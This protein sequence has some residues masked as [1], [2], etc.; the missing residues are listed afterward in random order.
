MTTQFCRPPKA[1]MRLLAVRSL[2]VSACALTITTARPLAAQ[3]GRITGLVT[4][5][6]GRPLA[7]TQVVVVPAG[8]Y[9]AMASV[10]GHYTISDI[11]PGT[12]RLQ[13]RRIGYAPREQQVTVSA[14]QT[15]IADF[16]LTAVPARLDTVRVG[17]TTQERRSVSDATAGTTGDELRTEKTATVEEA[18]RG[19]IPGVQIA[20]SGEPG[21]PAQVIIRGQNFVATSSGQQSPLYVV[22]G[23]YLQQNPNLNP[24]D[25]ESLE[26]LKDASAAAQ[27]GAQAANGVI[28]IR[29]RHGRA[30]E[31]RVELH[32]YYGYQD[33]PKRVS[34]MNTAQWAALTTQAYTNAG[35]PVIAGAATPPP[36]STDWQ[37]AVFTRGGIQ[38]HNLAM[39]GGSETANYLLS[40]GYL[41][42]DGA[43]INTG[44]ERY[45]FRVNSEARRSWIT[46]GENLAL[47]TSSKKN[48][49]G[50]PLIDALRM[51][52]TIPVYDPT[53]SS[54]FGFGSA[55]NPTF[56]VNPVG[57]QRIEDNTT[58]SNQV[59]GTTYAEIG[60]PAQLRYRFN[61]GIN[62]ENFGGRDFVRMGQLRLNN[63]LVPARLSDAQ[64]NTLSLLFE[65]LLTFDNTF[66]D[67]AHHLN[68]V[69][70]LTEQR[71]TV[72]RLS[73]YREGYTNYSLTTIDAGLTSNL[74]NGGNRFESALRALL[75]RAN[76]VFKDRYI[77]TGSVRRDGSSRFGPKNKYG[78]FGAISGGWVLSQEDFY[79]TM[80]LLGR[81]GY[82]K[83]RAS[84]GVLGNQ[85]IGDY[86]FDAAINQNL[87][88][89]FGNGVAN[90]ST[91][92]SL[93]NPNI[94]WQSNRETNVGLDLGAWNDRLSFTADYYQS[95]SSDILV[96]AP[97]PPSLGATGSPVVNAGSVRNTG[98]EFGATHKYEE[99]DL[100]LRTGATLTTVRNKVL[101][102]GNN[103]QPIIVRGV[104]RTAV[105][106][107]IGEF[108]VFIT[109]GIIQNA[110]EAAAVQAS[111]PG[112]VPGDIRY[113]KLSGTPG[114]LSDADRGYAGSPNPD[115]VGGLFMN[116]TYRRFDFGIN[117]HGS[118]GNKIFNVARWWTDRMDDLSNYRAGL[119]PWTPTNTATKTPRAVFGPAG[120]SNARYNSDRWIEDGSYLR[121]QNVSL[122][123]TLPATLA[124]RG[125]LQSVEPRLYLNIQNLYTFTHFSNWDPETLGFGD[126]LGRGIDDGFIFPNVRTVTVGLDL[127]F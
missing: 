107:P 91:Q 73:A 122:G 105:G 51:P 27:Y 115:F 23:M 5:E 125:G 95:T 84:T 2:V 110:A 61:L 103:S 53:T 71:Q 104:S 82:L 28:V 66:G 87:N 43:I 123:Y 120:A 4:A 16:Q 26:V 109:D 76:Y 13:A 58:K 21:R 67:G 63:P 31:N 93:A 127:R 55:A 49:N 86:Q 32:S 124:A 56:G 88:Y 29:T 24:D 97:I 54:G 68:A 65:N 77:L 92:L 12:Y 7:G 108:Y 44:F 80:P 98:F 90:G 75:L 114:L 101:S 60:L 112:A 8:R 118:H 6:N 47:S 18:L 36:F 64:A 46:F 126:A 9:G 81:A 102:L 3:S 62:Y 83:L 19:R 25:I 70:G 89:L 15:A 121:I 35:I 119:S 69:A 72:D 20:A 22:D 59:I 94:K 39:S 99:G 33:I 111:Q 30:G 106:H 117:M 14:D 34:M 50:F 78:N 41:K 52:P 10:E 74:N 40:G 113:K 79:N 96:N 1:A 48:L 17:Y 57:A 116:G 100:R 37:N 11:P 38:D 45:S 42:Q 85:D